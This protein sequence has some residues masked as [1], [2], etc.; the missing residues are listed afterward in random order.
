MPQ[1]VKE[2]LQY[3]LLCSGKDGEKLAVLEQLFE[4]A[5]ECRDKA[6]SVHRPAFSKPAGRGDFR[7][8]QEFLGIVGE[9][10]FKAL[11][12]IVQ[13]TTPSEVRARAGDIM[14]Q[15]WHPCAIGRLLETFEERREAKSDL[16]SSGIFKNLGGIG[17]EA[18]AKALMWLWGTGFD[19]EV[20]GALGMCDSAAAQDFLLRNAREHASPYVRSVCIAHLNLP[21]TEEKTDLLINCL[22]T[23]TQHEQFVAAMKVKEF[24]VA[25]AAPALRLLRAGTGDTVLVKVID[26][27]LSVLK[28]ES[29]LASGR[30]R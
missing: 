4:I 18:A 7:P 8:W 3:E 5:C 11:I 27:A 26:A 1:H 19:A 15:V 22:E 17:T 28:E 16:P 6:D 12:E 9:P 2:N 30:F 20:A 10:F 29:G 23:G 25:R 21:V 24:R 14:A 13:N